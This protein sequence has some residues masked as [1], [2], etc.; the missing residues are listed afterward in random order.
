MSYVF[1]VDGTLTPSRGKIDP[2]F[3]QFMLYFAGTNN[4]YMVTGSDREKTL[5]QIVYDLYHS[6]KRVYNCSGS[7]VWEGDRNVHTDDWTLPTDVEDFLL[8]ELYFS[9][10]PLRNGNHIE[11]RPGTV[12]FSILGRDKDPFLGRQEYVDWDKRTNER[13]DI[14][15]RLR[16]QFP[17][18]Y[19]ALGG[20][21]GLDIAPKG[22]GK[23]QII[24]DFEGGVK[25][26]GD[27]MDVGG[28][29]YTLAQLIR[30]RNL[31]T[32]YHVYDYKHT[33]ELLEYETTISESKGKKTTAV[34]KRS[35]D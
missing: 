31:G 12:N 30:E 23:E 14:A 1:D 33:W 22:R 27:K 35:T 6:C 5:D 26:F 7:D 21:T 8:D 10:F 28:N 29:D 20:Q 18:L 9:T 24:R 13:Q 3:L 34:G 17:D 19:I 4:V 11:R 16:T 2:E 32:T 15:D 25:F